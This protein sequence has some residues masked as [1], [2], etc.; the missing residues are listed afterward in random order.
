MT[1]H[2]A[3]PT[4][5]PLLHQPVMKR[6]RVCSYIARDGRS[7][8]NLAEPGTSRC[9]A[10]TRDRNAKWSSDRAGAEQ[11][12]FRKATLERDRFTCQ[13]CGLHDPT[14][15]KL[16]AHHVTPTHGTT[17]CNSKGNGCH[18]QVDAHAR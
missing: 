8:P 9:L 13:R 15:R 18:A 4:V 12:R 17:L 14:G 1:H 6:T 3:Y 16:D 2:F 5:I 7:C 10:H 11:H